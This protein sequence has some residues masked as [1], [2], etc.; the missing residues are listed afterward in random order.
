M[1]N[2]GKW[3]PVLTNKIFKA[4]RNLSQNLNFS[5]NKNKL[6]FTCKLY[7]EVAQTETK[8]FR[9]EIETPEEEKEGRFIPPAP[10]DGQAGTSLNIF[11]SKGSK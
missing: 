6:R 10:T 5:G 8:G 2:E 1:R 9:L 3:N 4:I 11:S 7:A